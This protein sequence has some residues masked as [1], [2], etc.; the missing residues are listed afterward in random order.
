MGR[1]GGG[2]VGGECMLVS[3]YGVGKA[4]F[5]VDTCYGEWRVRKASLPLS[6]PLETA[7]NPF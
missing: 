1:W 3:L 4:E 2:G 7:D 6:L 5:A